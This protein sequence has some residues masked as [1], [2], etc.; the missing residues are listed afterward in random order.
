MVGGI[1]AGG[2]VAG[3][4]MGVV[5]AQPFDSAGN[6]TV[7]LGRDNEPFAIGFVGQGYGGG[8][9]SFAPL[10]GWW[11]HSIVAW[12]RLFGRMSVQFSST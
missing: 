5:E 10:P 9:Q 7:S 2:V 4:L 6:P 8:C 12:I 3:G 11:G 1:G